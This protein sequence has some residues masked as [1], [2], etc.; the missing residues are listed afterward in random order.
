[1]TQIMRELSLLKEDRAAT[2]DG[3]TLVGF[4]ML[5]GAVQWSRT[6]PAK[7]VRI[8]STANGALMI[9]AGDTSNDVR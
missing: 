2:T 5:T 8:L 6:F 3:A 4:N 9:A 7:R 1:M